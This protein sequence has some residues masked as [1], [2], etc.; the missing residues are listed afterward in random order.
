MAYPP[1]GQA[2][3]APPP[4]EMKSD[5]VK[6]W[7]KRV[8]LAR[9]R[10]KRE[11]SVWKALQKNYLPPNPSAESSNVNSNVHF[12]DVHLKCA[13]LY[14]QLPPM[15]LTPKEPLYGL[16]DPQTG[17]P[18]MGAPGPD[19]QPQPMD[20]D[21]L[22]E[23]IVAVKT[24]LL[25]DITGPD[26][27]NMDWAIRRSLV[28]LLTASGISPVKICYESDIQEIQQEAPGPP[29]QMPGAVLG[30]QD[31][32]SA[33]VMQAVPVVVNE[34]IRVDAFSAAALLVP[35]DF[36]STNYD[37]ASYLGMEFEDRLNGRTKKL[38]NLPDGFKTFNTRGDLIINPEPSNI[39][40]GTSDIIRGIELWIRASEF[41]DSVANRDVFY[42]LVLIEG[43]KDKAA[44][45]ERSPYQTVGPDGR[46][47]FDSMRGNPIHPIYLRDATDTAWPKSDSAFT[48]PLVRNENTWLSQSVQLREANIPRFAHS[49]ALTLTA[50]KFK[51]MGVGNG[52]ALPAE[53]MAQGQERLMWQFP[54]LENAQSDIN[55][56]NT[57]KRAREETLG[58]GAN[59]A[60]SMNSG[61]RSATETAIVQ[62]NVSVRLKGERIVLAQHIVAIFRKVD[63][64]AMR[65]MSPGYVRILGQ[66]G[67]QILTMFDRQMI[68]GPYAYECNPDMMASIDEATKR[69]DWLKWTNFMAKSPYLNQEQNAR[70]G[71]QHFGY[72]ASRTISKPPPPPQPPPDK[73]RIT[74]SLQAGDLAIPEVQ[75]ALKMEGLDLTTQP[76]SPQL[77]AAHAA[78]Q[79]KNQPHGGAADRADLL[80]EHHSQMTGQQDGR[81]PV[82]PAPSTPAMPGT[83][84]H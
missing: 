28:S 58:T 21:T 47:T 41:D 20:P 61:R 26:M 30:L 40:E 19:G 69:E 42:R 68:S 84:L 35:Y 3:A 15:H 77:L 32:P 18:F 48:D 7:W 82:A 79:A 46:L 4:L 38:Y 74:L 59:Q 31:V 78:L 52:V 66:A 14:A 49:D 73:P 44:I 50:D 64:L 23:H 11:V 70:T 67:A 39:S 16:K 63:A 76:P 56:Y 65:Y 62:Q 37:Q 43:L 57:I 24:A 33:P 80:S 5:D 53:V 83:G 2:P 1:Q 72:D 51:L 81:P 75:L 25:T 9:E 6:L 29:T 17:Q 54:H 34:R 36:Y 8:E 27:A 71:A 55:G 10:K 60:G 12:R 22:A 45:Y 13:E